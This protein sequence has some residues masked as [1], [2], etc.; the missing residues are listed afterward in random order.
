MFTG[1]GDQKVGIQWLKGRDGAVGHPKA[2]ST[3][4]AESG[5]LAMTHQEKDTDKMAYFP[6]GS[7]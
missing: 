3:V 6:G 7:L 4:D 5:H 2:S 1:I